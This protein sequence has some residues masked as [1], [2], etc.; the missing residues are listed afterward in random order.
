MC[1]VPGETTH[2]L[3]PLAV[4][5]VEQV[6]P[7]CHPSRG[8]LK[9]SISC[10]STSP[11]EAALPALSPLAH[12]S[13]V[14]WWSASGLQDPSSCAVTGC[15]SCEPAAKHCAH[16]ESCCAGYWSLLLVQ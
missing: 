1:L 11:P 8:N 9:P 3:P 13:A 7:S 14:C 15:N 12:V 5:S 16:T 6:T 10:R 2:Q 4:C